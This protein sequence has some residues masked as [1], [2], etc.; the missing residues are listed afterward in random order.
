MSL[1]QHQPYPSPPVKK[2]CPSPQQIAQ[3]LFENH[4]IAAEAIAKIT[5]DEEEYIHGY[6]KEEGEWYRFTIYKY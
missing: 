5:I 1:R 6:A 3:L 2:S 4:D